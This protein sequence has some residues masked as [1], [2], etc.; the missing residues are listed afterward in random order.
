MSNL[1]TTFFGPVDEIYCTYFLIISMIFLI[2]FIIMFL[3]EIRYIMLN[4]NRL[5]YK[6]LFSGIAI[7]F[8]IFI[9]YFMNRMLYT[10]CVKTH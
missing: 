6:I 8:N 10:M 9:V 3:A 4:Y 5:N 2:V 7:L 1:M